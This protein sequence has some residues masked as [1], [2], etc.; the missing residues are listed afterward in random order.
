MNDLS[1][2]KRK[3]RPGEPGLF[4]GTRFLYRA[5]RVVIGAAPL[6]A[7]PLKSSAV[8]AALTGIS[9]GNPVAVIA[10]PAQRG[11]ST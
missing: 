7:A 4:F 6:L 3:K 5:E 10:T 8:L 9:A 11:F 1:T 2:K